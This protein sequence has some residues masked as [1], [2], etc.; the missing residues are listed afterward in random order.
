[1]DN[2]Q[3][4]DEGAIN[5]IKTLASTSVYH[6]E[7]VVIEDDGSPLEILTRTN[8]MKLFQSKITLPDCLHRPVIPHC[9]AS[10]S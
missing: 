8:K 1:M 4:C 2:F 5:R 6:P 3:E 10:L 7:S 9:A